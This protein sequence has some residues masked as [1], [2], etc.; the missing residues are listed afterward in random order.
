V[1]KEPQGIVR[2]VHLSTG[3][4][5][6]RTANL[7]TDISLFT[8]RQEFG[9]DASAVFNMLTGYCEPPAFLKLIVAPL[10][11]RQWL[12]NKIHDEEKAGPNGRIFAQMNSLVDSRVIQALYRASQA[13]VRVDLV[14]RGI[15]CL[16][17]GVE[18]ISDNIRVYQIVDRFLE[19]RR[20]FN[21]EAGGKNEVYLGSADWMNRNLNRRVELLFPVEDAALKARLLDEIIKTMM[22]DTVKVRQLGEDGRYRVVPV[23]DGEPLVRSQQRFM[24]IARGRKLAQPD[25]RLTDRRVLTV[26][27][28]AAKAAGQ[29]PS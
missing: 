18:G 22:A 12:I 6:P 21:F 9:E 23:L 15:C 5:N 20:V 26:A 1:R 10:Y 2:Y 19:H 11:L 27:P 24:D 13:G 16:R 8:N 29:A 17:P 7:Y 25:V 4:Y 28:A 3:N 14:V